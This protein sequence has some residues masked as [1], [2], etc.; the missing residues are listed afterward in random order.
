MIQQTHKREA[1]K[2]KNKKKIKNRKHPIT[3]LILLTI[4]LPTN[5]TAN[6]YPPV[7]LP[8]HQSPATGGT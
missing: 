4:I 1:R 8:A 6:K 5:S 7:I 3:I 2:V